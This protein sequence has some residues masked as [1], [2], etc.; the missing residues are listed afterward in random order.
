MK[1][2]YL[3]VPFNDRQKAKSLGCKWEFYVKL[4]YTTTPVDKY[5]HKWCLK[6]NQDKIE[7]LFLQMKDEYRIRKEP[8]KSRKRKHPWDE[9]DYEDNYEE[10]LC[11]HCLLSDCI[12]CQLIDETMDAVVKIVQN[13]KCRK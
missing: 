2:Y 3:N 9:V 5:F 13:I 1:R 4:W 11:S 7:K 12:C 8:K 10:K 6:D